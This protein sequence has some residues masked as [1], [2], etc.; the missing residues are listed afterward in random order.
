M[1]IDT[2]FA[3]FNTTLED[4]VWEIPKPLCPDPPS[5]ETKG[6]PKSTTASSTTPTGPTPKAAAAAEAAAAAMSSS[7]PNPFP[8]TFGAYLTTNISQAG[9]EGGNVVTSIMADCTDGPANQIAKTTYGN[10]HTVLVDC[11]QRLVYVRR[12]PARRTP[13]A[14]RHP[15]PAAHRLQPAAHNPQPT[16][17]LLFAGITMTSMASIALFKRS[18]GQTAGRETSTHA[19]ATRVRCRLAS[20]TRRVFTRPT[21]HRGSNGLSMMVTPFKRPRD[22]NTNTNTRARAHTH[23]HQSPPP[24]TNPSIAAR[25]DFCH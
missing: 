13:S 4:D 21:E 9:Y 22:L 1:T 5:A 6:S 17:H 19:Y 11:T 7:G 12:A 10:F 15:P 20:V 25:H 24:S 8:A 23:T 14:A 16:T 3:S 2:Y 18:V